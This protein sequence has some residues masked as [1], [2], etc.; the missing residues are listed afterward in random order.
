[1]VNNKPIEIW[2][3][4]IIEQKLDYIHMNPVEAGFVSEPEHWKYSSAIDYSGGKGIIE[5][6]IL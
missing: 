3:V 2:S 1:M 6:D 4:D 5:I